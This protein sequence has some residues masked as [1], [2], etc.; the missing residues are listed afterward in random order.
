MEDPR[1]SGCPGVPRPADDEVDDALLALVGT[2]ATGKGTC[3]DFELVNRLLQDWHTEAA[4]RWAVTEGRQRQLLRVTGA[5]SSSRVESDAAGKLTA[6][7]VEGVTLTLSD[8]G[9][10]WWLHRTVFLCPL[11]SPGCP[12]PMAEVEGCI[13]DFLR[14]W[15]APDTFKGAFAVEAIAKHWSGRPLPGSTVPAHNTAVGISHRSHSEILWALKT[16]H[17]RGWIVAAAPLDNIRH[18]APGRIRWEDDQRHRLTRAP[19]WNRIVI[20]VTEA[21]WKA[22][23]AGELPLA[24]PTRAERGEGGIMPRDVEAGQVGGTGHDMTASPADPVLVPPFPPDC[25]EASRDLPDSAQAGTASSRALAR[26]N[27]QLAAHQHRE[28]VRRHREQLAEVNRADEAIGALRVS[29]GAM[30]RECRQFGVDSFEAERHAAAIAERL[31]AAVT[32]LGRERLLARWREVDQAASAEAAVRFM[33]HPQRSGTGD[34]VPRSDRANVEVACKIVEECLTRQS[35]DTGELTLDL[36]STVDAPRWACGILHALAHFGSW[37]DW[38][39]LTQRAEEAVGGTTVDGDQSPADDEAEAREI[40]AKS[41][42][43][44][45][46]QKKTKAT[47]PPSRVKAMSQFVDAVSKCPA[48]NGAT[49]REVYDWIDEHSDGDPLPNF[50]T[51]SRYLRD[52]R[53]AA[54]ISKNTPR[55]ERTGRSIVRLDEI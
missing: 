55:S 15:S 36:R 34:A 1:S 47:L 17:E 41:S 26:S 20:R 35:I 46:P 54:G 44:A 25:S 30:E 7:P 14:A 9:I 53:E 3:P 8:G 2:L 45:P 19:E 50:D 12:P 42:D 33:Y 51:W 27:A 4:C 38:L 23:S 29:V 43:S 32:E 28:D 52:A 31:Q 5:A 39:I 18:L 48:L 11:P 49:D 24:S 16:M 37:P 22:H 10:K 13:R 21:G 6:V 40:D